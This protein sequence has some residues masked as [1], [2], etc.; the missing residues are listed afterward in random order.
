MSFEQL[1]KLKEEIGSKMYNK[2]VHGD[3]N[4]KK[5]PKKQFTRIN[6]NRP[7]ERS[8]K[9]KARL[10]QRQ[11]PNIPQPKQQYSRDP[12]FDEKCGT[13]DKDQFRNDYKF[14]EEIKRDERKQLAAEYEETKDGDKKKQIKLLIQRIVGSISWFLNSD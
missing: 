13:F 8:A 4:K 2:T 11:I 3:N 6:K 10:I 7:R 9:I 12:R 5:E 1:Q 14:V